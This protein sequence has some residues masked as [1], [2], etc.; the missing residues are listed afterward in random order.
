MNIKISF[1]IPVFNVEKYIKRCILSIENQDIPREEYELIIVNDGTL[2]NS[3]EIIKLLQQQFSNIILVNKKNGGLSSARNFGIQYASGKYIWFIDSDDFIDSNVLRTII[4][5]AYKE[6]LDVL[7]FGNKDIYPNGKILYPYTSKPSKIVTGLEFLRH[8]QLSIAAW[9]CIAKKT[10]YTQYHIQFT[11][12]IYHE[13]YEFILAL[14]EH[15]CKIAY[16]DIYPYNYIIKENG[17]ITTNKNSQHIKKRLDSWLCII[18]NI[19]HK[20]PNTTDP[21]TYSYYANRWCNVYKFHA[22]SALILLPLPFNDKKNYIH[23][24]QEIG[25]FPIGPCNLNMRR[26]FIAIIYSKPIFYTGVIAIFGVLNTFYKS[27][28]RFFK[29]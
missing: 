13:D 9:T 25:C 14:Y 20:Y 19:T 10:L 29:F 27:M 24:F 6:D 11:E 26:K 4:D 5:N 2:D 7:C 3:I 15:S 8:Y 12:G 17:T 22:L 1:I 23:K 21:S 16:M 18:K 28:Q